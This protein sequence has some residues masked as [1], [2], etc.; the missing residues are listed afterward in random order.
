MLKEKYKTLGHLW[1]IN[2][3]E[4]QYS[5]LPCPIISMRNGNIGNMYKIMHN[6][7][8]TVCKDFRISVR[9]SVKEDTRTK[10]LYN[11]ALCCLL[12]F[13]DHLGSNL[14]ASFTFL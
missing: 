2:V 7:F 11:F 14:T 5:I 9:V 6:S 4:L 1:G 10:I 8:H 13:C 12:K 3:K